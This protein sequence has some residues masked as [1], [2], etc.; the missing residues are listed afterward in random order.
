[1]QQEVIRH[2]IVASI[3]ACHAGDRGSI[4]RDGVVLSEYLLLL[5]LFHNMHT[6]DQTA[7]C[8]ST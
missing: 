5:Y 6:A 1:M 3:P 8:K 2:S 7:F 4:P